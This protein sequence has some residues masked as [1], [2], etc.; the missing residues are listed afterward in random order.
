MIKKQKIYLY[1]AVAYIFSLAFHLY[2]ISWANHIPQ[3]F[4]H[5]QLMINNPDGYYFASDSQ[6]ILYNMHKYNLNLSHPF[7]IGLGVITAFFVKLFPFLSLDTVILYLSAIISSLIVIPVILIGKLYKNLEWGFLA[8][9]LASIGWSFYNRTLVGYYDTDMFSV[10]DI[11]VVLY[12]FLDSMKNKSSLSAFF[13]FLMIL[14]NEW[15]YPSGNM[16]IFAVFIF[17]AVYLFFT[18]KKFLYKFLIIVSIAFISI[19][20]FI[21]LIIGVVFYYLILQNKIKNEKTFGTIVFLISIVFSHASIAIFLRV[22]SYVSSQVKIEG[23]HFLNVMRTVREASHIPYYIIADRIIGS[24]IGIVISVIGYIL[25]V[26]KYK[27][28]IIALPLWGVGF[29]AFFGGLRFTVHAVPIAALSATYLLFYLAEKYKKYQKIIIYGGFLFLIAPNITHIV[30]CCEK[31]KTLAFFEK[32]YPLRSYPYLVPTVLN[33]N[34]V[35]VLD[36]L[37]HISNE[38]DYVLTWWDYGYPIWY[39]A[40]VNTL[41]DGG[42][43]HQ[44]NYL[45]SKILTTSNQRLAYNLGKLSIKTYIKINE[46]N[47]TVKPAAMALFVKNGKPVNVNAF[48]EKIS[49][50]NFK[51]VKLDRNL[52]LMLPYRMFNIFPTVAEFSNRNLNTG[53]VYP[54]HFF[55][56]ARIYQKNGMLYIGSIPVDINNGVLMIQKGIPIKEI[57][58]VGY[59]KNMK[60]KIRKNRLRDNGL[61]LIVLRSYGEALVLDDYYYNSTFVQMFVF[62]NY[63][64]NLFEPVILNPVM[65]IYR[66]K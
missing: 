57:D 13:A 65:K 36:K 48:L 24:V 27:E 55:Y 56:K 17:A 46:K 43:H 59:D 28:F 66:F 22:Y 12:L 47:K 37:K 53:K 23:L 18:D 40:D 33:K 19:N 7:Q 41:I 58:I 51:S 10:L 21:K 62:E 29:F 4:W 20:I 15:V 61:N 25:L 11:T 8:A 63:D 32:Y 45:I 26:K 49:D 50:E 30:G 2:W 42:K 44:D 60:L 52:Y 6:K 39:Y 35:E 38:K 64:K 16:I 1:I 14:F 54:P 31:N 5:G 34:E 3:F 9:L